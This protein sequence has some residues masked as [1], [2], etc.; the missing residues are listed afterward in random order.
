M[1]EAHFRKTINILVQELVTCVS[2]LIYRKLIG[3]YFENLFLKLL[4]LTVVKLICFNS[5]VT[6]ILLVLGKCQQTFK[7]NV[8]GE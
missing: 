7:Y 3:L 4:K 5:V 1:N 8:K 6:L 2:A